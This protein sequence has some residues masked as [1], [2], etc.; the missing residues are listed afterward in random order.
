MAC[1]PA[2]AG[3]CALGFTS[4]RLHVFD[5]DGDG[6]HDVLC[7]SVWSAYRTQVSVVAGQLNTQEPNEQGNAILKAA[8][9][10]QECAVIAVSDASQSAVYCATWPVEPPACAPASRSATTIMAKGEPRPTCLVAL[11]DSI[12][13]GLGLSVREDL[14]PGRGWDWRGAGGY[15]PYLWR[16]LL[17]R[18]RSLE[19]VGSQDQLYLCASDVEDYGGSHFPPWHESLWGWTAAGVTTHLSRQLASYPCQPECVIITLGTVE[20]FQSHDNPCSAV[21]ISVWGF[22]KIA[23]NL[24]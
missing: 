21:L 4:A 5:C 1:T 16:H 6:L 13:S 11:G 20:M 15:R 7:T 22:D 17:D 2:P 3:F 14:A 12:T 19:W 23:C 9:S 10:S 24:Q 8:L 18:G